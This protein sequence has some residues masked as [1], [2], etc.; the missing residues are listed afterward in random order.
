MYFICDSFAP[1]IANPRCISLQYHS[2]LE[3]WKN[4]QSIKLGHMECIV[5]DDNEEGPETK[6]N[7]TFL[8]TLGDGPCPKSF[9][10][11]V[12]RLAGLPDDV[13][14]KAKAVSSHFE[15]EMN[16]QT[17][18][19]IIKASKMALDVK[20]LLSDVENCDKLTAKLWQS[21]Q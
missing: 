16:G 18:Q 14:Q 5:E 20:R 7:I 9:G 12:A 1:L 2:L 8:Y 19:H 21:L 4:E 17:G 3:D 13:L 6:N 10:V 15:A 11:N